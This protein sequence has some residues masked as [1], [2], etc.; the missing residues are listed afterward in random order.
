MKRTTDTRELEQALLAAQMAAREIEATTIATIAR[1]DGTEESFP[2]APS[3]LV[4]RE[5]RRLLHLHGLLLRPA[6]VLEQGGHIKVVYVL[7]HPASGA[8]LDYTYSGP[9]AFSRF[10]VPE[11]AVAAAESYAWRCLVLELLQIPVVPMRVVIAPPTVPPPRHSIRPLSTATRSLLAGAPVELPD[12]TNERLAKHVVAW[13]ELEADRRR[14]DGGDYHEPGLPDA[15]EA[16]LRER[17]V[18]ERRK[19]SDDAERREL[20]AF[21]GREQALHGYE[22]EAA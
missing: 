9:V 13:C 2:F 1:D 4:R 8:S 11:H 19:P 21:L 3:H 10:A 15:M 5:A 22:V 16:C 17:G 18:G 12:F 7:S 14:A 6:E 20:Y